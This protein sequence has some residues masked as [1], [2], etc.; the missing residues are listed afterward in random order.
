MN[1]GIAALKLST[2]SRIGFSIT[3]VLHI[4]QTNAMIIVGKHNE[5]FLFL[6]TICTGIVMISVSDLIPGLSK[7]LILHD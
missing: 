7:P 2:V 1:T 6:H 5:L 3:Y 4:F